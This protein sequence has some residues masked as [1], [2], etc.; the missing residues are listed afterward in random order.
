MWKEYGVYREI[1]AVGTSD[2]YSV[3]HSA[4]IYV[5]DKANQLRMTYPFGAD[6]DSITSDIRFLLKED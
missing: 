2:N 6:V 4:F 3:D 5:I 1:Q